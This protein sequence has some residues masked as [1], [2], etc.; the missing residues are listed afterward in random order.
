MNAGTIEGSNYRYYRRMAWQVLRARYAAEVAAEM[1]AGVPAA[2]ARQRAAR[3][4][5]GELRA[6][7][8][9]LLTHAPVPRSSSS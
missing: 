8:S 4:V 2:E 1:D 9:E 5:Q 3:A 7:M 6:L